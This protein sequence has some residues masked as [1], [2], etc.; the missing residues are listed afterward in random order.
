MV[1][2]W[3]PR[4]S[5]S[6]SILR[7]VVVLPDPEGPESSTTGLR[8]IFSII[9]PAA[10]STLSWKRASPSSMKAAGSRRTASLMRSRR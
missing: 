10:A 4:R 9:R 5:S 6:A 3:T 8:T 7:A 1:W 2:V